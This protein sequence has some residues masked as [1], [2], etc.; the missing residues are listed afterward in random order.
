[1][2]RRLIF[3]VT[4]LAF[5]EL[6][7]SLLITA[8][9]E[10]A[11]QEPKPTSVAEGRF[12]FT[13][14]DEDRRNN[15]PFLSSL[16]TSK[17]LQLEAVRTAAANLSLDVGA[18]LPEVRFKAFP[19]PMWFE[20][21]SFDPRL[22][23]IKVLEAWRDVLARRLL[24]ADSTRT[25]LQMQITQE[26][27][28]TAELAARLANDRDK[29]AALALAAEVELDPAVAAQKR[30]R[31]ETEL[32]SLTIEVQGLEARKEVLEY[33]IA[34][35]AKKASESA[36]AADPVL[37]ELTK[38]VEARQKIVEFRQAQF[39]AGAQGTSLENVELAKDELAQAELELAKYRRTLADVA[40]GQRLA[41][42]QRRR[43]DVAFD[44]AEATTK[45]RAVEKLVEQARKHSTSVE[46]KRIDL[47]LQEQDYRRAREELSQLE[48]KL[49]QHISPS[50][51]LIPLN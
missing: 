42:L 15:E 36:S 19:V 14:H 17:P 3:V 46:I 37:A 38:S 27:R 39:A 24:D 9:A 6:S 7:A 30:I 51:T 28:R 29:L 41:E 31:L 18:E 1:M 44:L 25:S 49:R 10:D 2:L 33:Q 16:L 5:T 21:S 4:I 47:E 43:E 8:K 45:S 22:P 35:L 23:A 26:Q 13:S 34:E 20:V 48:S 50:V 12:H 32:L 11:P 40:A